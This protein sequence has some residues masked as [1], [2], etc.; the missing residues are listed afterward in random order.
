[1]GLD[2]S[3]LKGQRL[4]PA[5]VAGVVAMGCTLAPWDTAGRGL[6]Q[7]QLHAFARDEEERRV[8]GKLAW[9]LRANPTAWI[10]P[11]APPFLVLVAESERYAP[12]ALE[13]G[14]RFVRLLREQGRSADL[15]F[16]PGRR[17]VTTTTG[18]AD[19]ADAVANLVAEFMKRPQAVT[20]TP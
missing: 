14:A 20:A 10:G 19:P 4:R 1:M 12:P 13:E 18:F 5:D 3:D 15:R 7:A 17:H 9:R 11:D 6:T 16:L 2:S 8:Y